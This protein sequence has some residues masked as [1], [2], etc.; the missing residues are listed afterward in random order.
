VRSSKQGQGGGVFG[1]RGKKN[2]P[3][4]ECR[5]DGIQPGGKSFAGGKWL[6]LSL[7]GSLNTKK[8]VACSG[9]LLWWG[10]E[11]WNTGMNIVKK[12]WGGT[13]G[14]TVG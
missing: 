10:A 13:K 12:S 5:K 11:R 7:G 4:R 14:R 6:C 1:Q 3:W 9:L 2:S 8:V